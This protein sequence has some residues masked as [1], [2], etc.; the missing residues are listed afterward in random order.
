MERLTGWKDLLWRLAV[1][2]SFCVVFFLVWQPLRQAAAVH[3][4]KP[5]LAMIASTSDTVSDVTVRP[6]PPTVFLNFPDDREHVEVAIPAGLYYFLP[7]V[8]LLFVAPRKPWWLVLL[9]FALALGILEF[10][11]AVVG[12]LGIEFGF[13]AHEFVQ[14]HLIKP[15][16]IAV[17]LTL[18]TGM[19]KIG[20]E[21]AP[22][23]NR[24]RVFL[25]DER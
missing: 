9:L 24:L 20:W 6:R 3:V 17:P 21:D 19:W 8:F 5:V 25:S 2:V 23:F 14:R 18:I 15:L 12:V 22:V 7:A 10:L 16:S 4:A 11:C 13:T 1:V